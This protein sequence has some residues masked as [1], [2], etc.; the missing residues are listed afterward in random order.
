M[1]NTAKENATADSGV[2]RVLQMGLWRWLIL[3][4]GENSWLG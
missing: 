2:F 1:T 3:A 4:D